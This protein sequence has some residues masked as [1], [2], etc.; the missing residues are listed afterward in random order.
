MEPARDEPVRQEIRTY[1]VVQGDS[2]WVIAQ[3]VYGTDKGYLGDNILKANRDIVP[4]P[5]AL[6]IGLELTIPPAPTPRNATADAAP[7][8]PAQS[9][10]GLRRYTVVENDSLWK[11]SKKVYG[12]GAHY[13]KILTAN[14]DKLS[15]ESAVLRKGMT[16]II[17]SLEQQPSQPVT[18]NTSGGI[19]Q[20]PAAVQAEGAVYTTRSGDSFWRIAQRFYGDGTRSNELFEANKDRL[21]IS[22]PSQLD[23]GKVIVLPG[24][25]QAEVGE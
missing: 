13:K 4:D 20:M 25:S 22:S 8:Q 15:S 12:N 21:R 2:F 14:R 11:I 18:D 7:E 16:L 6:K 5:G 10:D 9:T 24:L 17:P 3:K 23:E 19:Q 1:K